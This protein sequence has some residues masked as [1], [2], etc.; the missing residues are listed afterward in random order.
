MAYP[1]VSHL[2]LVAYTWRNVLD[3]ISGSDQGASTVCDK[4]ISLLWYSSSRPTA[5]RVKV[6]RGLLRAIPLHTITM[7]QS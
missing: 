1:S 7:F 2:N 6:Y 5:K 3:A 4:N